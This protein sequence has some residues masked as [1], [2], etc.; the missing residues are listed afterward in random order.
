MTTP[1]PALAAMLGGITTGE[2]RAV[3]LTNVL[4]SDF[5]VIVLPLEFGQRRLGSGGS[6]GGAQ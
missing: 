5:P 6:C 3:D 4:S 2:I 1:H